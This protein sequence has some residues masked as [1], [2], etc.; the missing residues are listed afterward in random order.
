VGRATLRPEA[1]RRREPRV[2]VAIRAWVDD[3]RVRSAGQVADASLRGLLIELPEPPLFA[4]REVTVTLAL[5]QTGMLALGGTIVRRELRDRCV[6]LAIRLS[7][8]LDVPA[9]G[10]GRRGASVPCVSGARPR[11]IAAA[12]VGALGTGALEL[13]ALGGDEPVPPEL[14]DWLEHLAAELGEG[15]HVQPSTASDLMEAVAALAARR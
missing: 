11:G 14:T 8:A 4:E 6:V 3:G 7:E 15:P 10:A 12:E 1:E 9:A 13:S 2:P 5:G